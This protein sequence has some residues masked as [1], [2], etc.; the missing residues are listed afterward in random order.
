MYAWSQHQYD[1]DDDDEHKSG[2]SSYPAYHYI[3]PTEIKKAKNSGI[4]TSTTA[5]IL[6]TTTNSAEPLHCLAHRRIQEELKKKGKKFNKRTYKMNCAIIHTCDPNDLVYDDAYDEHDDGYD[7]GGEEH[8][9][10]GSY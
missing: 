3:T 1:Y 7:Y 10:Y 9:E 5:D 2:S 8:Y 4:I 6:S